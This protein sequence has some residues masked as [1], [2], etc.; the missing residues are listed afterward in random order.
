MN[1]VIRP[2]VRSHEIIYGVMPGIMQTQVIPLDELVV[3]VRNDSFYLRWL[4]ENK[5]ILIRAGHMLN[6]MRA[7]AVIRLLSEF[8]QDGIALMSDFSWADCKDFPFLP[9]IQIG[10]IV[11]SLA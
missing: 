10:R 1:V 3:G 5:K 6:A 2:A 7:P 4:R 11:L 8:G 9:R